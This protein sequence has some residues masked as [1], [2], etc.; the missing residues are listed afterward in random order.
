[1]LDVLKAHKRFTDWGTGAKIEN[2]VRAAGLGPY[3][4]DLHR[5]PGA[6]QIAEMEKAVQGFFDIAHRQR[7]ENWLAAVTEIAK[8][9]IQAERNAR[10]LKFIWEVRNLFDSLKEDL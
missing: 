4:Q 8:M 1:M 5:K 2:I 10:H 9:T 3:I 7:P 6:I